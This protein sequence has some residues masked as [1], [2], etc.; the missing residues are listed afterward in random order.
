MTL[1]DGRTVA[2]DDIG[3]REGFPVIYNHGF[4][5]SRL[6]RGPDDTAATRAGLRV[7]CLDRPGYGGSSPQA[8]Y[9]LWGWAADVQQVADHLGIGRFA[10]LGWSGGCAYSLAIARYLDDRVTHGVL[11]SS[12]VDDPQVYRLVQMYRLVHWFFIV[13]GL[14]RGIPPLQQALPARMSRQA[15]ADLDA[16]VESFLTP[17]AS[18]PLSEP[19]RALL[20][21]P[22]M[23]E[24]W[25]ANWTEVFRQGPAG[26]IPDYMAV[27]RTEGFHVQDV[28]Q[29]MDLFH[30]DRD[31]AVK[32][33][34]GKMM[35]E[36]LPDADLYIIRGA[37]HLCLL[38][39]W[40]QILSA[41]AARAPTQ[42]TTP[43]SDVPSTGTS[44]APAAR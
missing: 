22:T 38:S 8:Y 10:V 39:H 27:D 5:N 25:K 43:L 33:L 37:G 44:P 13:P 36:H 20:R 24:Q 28:R 19:D 3:D 29:H 40:E 15:H 9:T 6:G 42:T 12:G 31:I 11:V 18:N 2:F 1:R 23:R 17:H 35:A 30:G 14:L 26:V 34:A 16:L 7:I 32:P 4:L 21:D 41:V